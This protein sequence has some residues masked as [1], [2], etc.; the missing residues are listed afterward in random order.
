MLS[1]GSIVSYLVLTQV[2]GRETTARLGGWSRISPA[3]AYKIIGSGQAAA[4]SKTVH[5]CLESVFIQQYGSL[6]VRP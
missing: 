3:H 4:I 5:F 6:P 2:L 1:L